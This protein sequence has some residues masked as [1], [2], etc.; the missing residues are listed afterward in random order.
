MTSTAPT[1]DEV[2]EV[3][4]R[5]GV[6]QLCYDALTQYLHSIPKIE[7]LEVLRKHLCLANKVGHG[8]F[9]EIIQQMLNL[10][11]PEEV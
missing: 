8:N 11:L 6:C 5:C 9:H 4:D 2:R 1:D 3:L 7:Q 10:T